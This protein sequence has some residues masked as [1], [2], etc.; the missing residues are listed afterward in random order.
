MMNNCNIMLTEKQQNYRLHHLV[1]LIKYEYLKGEEILP[2]NQR[3]VIE[4]GK[5]T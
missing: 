4:Q 2:L 3:G 5:L 1:K